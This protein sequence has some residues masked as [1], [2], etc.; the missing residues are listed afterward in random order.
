MDVSVM[1]MPHAGRHSSLIAAHAIANLAA[2][3]SGYDEVPQSRLL[4]A[5]PAAPPTPRLALAS[6]PEIAA[7][8]AA[9]LAEENVASAS[10]ALA[11]LYNLTTTEGSMEALRYQLKSQASVLVAACGFA[12]SCLSSGLC[13]LPSLPR[14]GFVMSGL[15][16]LHPPAMIEQRW[17][18]LQF[19]PVLC[20][21]SPHF[22]AAQ[23][24]VWANAQPPALRIPNLEPR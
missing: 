18:S 24:S 22:K 7:G 23:S 8:L 2:F 17:I 20:C 14:F 15:R 1:D 3:R 4:G 5:A 19:S 16:V 21:E 11:A 9:M 6:N 12:L 13:R 10:A